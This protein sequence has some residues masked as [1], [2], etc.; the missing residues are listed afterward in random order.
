M[1]V[2]NGTLLQISHVGYKEFNIESDKSLVLKKLLHVPRIQKNLMSVSKLTTDNNVSVEFFPNGCVVKDL[3][4]N[5][6][7]VQRKL[8]DGLY[9]LNLPN[10]RPPN[11]SSF[12]HH[13]SNIT[14]NLLNTSLN[15][16]TNST[17]HNFME[18]QTEI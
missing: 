7:L 9:Q 4:T 5:K 8:E 15:H 14:H 16:T 13:Q 1:I 18:A 11:T 10:S 3:P 2:G 6:A 17:S 12:N